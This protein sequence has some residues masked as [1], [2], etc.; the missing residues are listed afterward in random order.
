MLTVFS[1]PVREGPKKRSRK[2]FTCTLET[3]GGSPI[4]KNTFVRGTTRSLGQ[5]SIM[6]KTGKLHGGG[7]REGPPLLKKELYR[8]NCTGALKVVRR[9][10]AN[11]KVFRMG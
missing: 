11:K 10:A 8:L 4:G 2:A 7:G 1:M 3:K 6:E 5:L 9:V